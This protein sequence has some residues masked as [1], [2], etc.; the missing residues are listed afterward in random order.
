MSSMILVEILGRVVQANLIMGESVMDST[1]PTHAGD[2]SVVFVVVVVAGV[3]GMTA[4]TIVS[5]IGIGILLHGQ[6]IAVLEA[7]AD[8]V[9]S[10]HDLI[11]RLKDLQQAEM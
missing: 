5:K 3:D 11:V 8:S 7:H 1:T 2:S 9:G 4:T 10:G 6:E